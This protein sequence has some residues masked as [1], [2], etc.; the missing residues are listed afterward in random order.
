MSN[1]WEYRFAF[2][3]E[4]RNDVPPEFRTAYERLG[5]ANGRPIYGL[6]TPPI[7]EHAFIVSRW[8]PPKLI[9]VFQERSALLAL[10]CNSN[11]V[12]AFEQRRRDF[13]GFGLA[14]FL[15]NCWFTLYAGDPAQRQVEVRFP[16]RAAQHY[17]ELTR[18]LLNWCNGKEEIDGQEPSSL[19]KLSGLPSKFTSFLHAHPELGTVFEFF[20]QPAMG[21]RK[22]HQKAFS[23][24][25][26]MMTSRGIFALG[27][28]YRNECSE[29]GIEMT[30]LPSSR[31][32][33]A[34]W[35]ESA[36]GQQAVIEISMHGAAVRWRI[37]WPVNVGL[38]PY[39]L[40]WIQ[41]VNAA[42]KISGGEFMPE[43]GMTSRDNDERG[44][45]L[46]SF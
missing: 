26:L 29:Y 6:F 16:A 30:C 11:Q 19:R 37:S 40:R 12:H 28:Q 32:K 9:L 41:A 24:L 22:S 17:G 10:D 36:N 42:I 34:E 4:G 1:T 33:T 3:V 21:V 45:Y 2:R 31:I 8:I 27:D 20:F 23:N 38:R 18:L 7:K 43:E 39:A 46:H 15:L 44:R 14:E 35:I 25:L 5:E 13:L